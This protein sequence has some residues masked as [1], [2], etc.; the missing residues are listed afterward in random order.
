VAIHELTHDDLI[1]VKPVTFASQNILEREDLQRILRMHIDAVAPDTFVIAEEFADW[2]G[3]SRS[4]DILCLVQPSEIEGLILPLRRLR[5]EAFPC[6][7]NGKA[8][9]WFG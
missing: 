6:R 5:R 8:W 9:P 7:S 1:P 4:I 2:E 3:S